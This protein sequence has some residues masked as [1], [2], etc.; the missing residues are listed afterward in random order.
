MYLLKDGFNHAINATITLASNST[1]IELPETL[2]P[3]SG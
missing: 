2:L 1:S 3:P